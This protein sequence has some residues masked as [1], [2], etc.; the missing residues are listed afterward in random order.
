MKIER[1]VFEWL[2]AGSITLQLN[3]KGFD[4]RFEFTTS[5]VRFLPAQNLLGLVFGI[6]ALGRILVGQQIIL[7][8]LGH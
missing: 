7:L 1:N 5:V 6:E 4:K 3:L 8:V 2:S